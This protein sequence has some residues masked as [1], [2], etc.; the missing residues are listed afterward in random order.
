MAHSMMA[1][2]KTVTQNI[3]FQPTFLCKKE[4]NMF[5]RP[6]CWPCVH[7]HVRPIQL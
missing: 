1:A 4:I 2:I 3:H 6:L 7:L 5:M